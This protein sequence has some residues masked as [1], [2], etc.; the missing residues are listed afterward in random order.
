[1]SKQEISPSVI[2]RL[3]RYHRFLGELAA[4]GTIRISSKELSRQMGLTASQI[5]Q[6]LNCFGGFGQQGYGYNVCA[7]R[8]EIGQILGIHAHRK[9]I[10][11]G[12]GNLGRAIASHVNFSQ[13]GCDLIGLFDSNPFVAGRDIEGMQVHHTDTLSGFC[14]QESPE[15]AILCVPENAAAELANKLVSFGVRA[16]WNF[17][18]SNLHFEDDAV[19]VEN[20][21]LADSLMTL[22]YGLSHDSMDET[23]DSLR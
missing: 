22:T 6:D 1:M 14:R 12:L 15:L 10:L 9:T 20:V 5:R 8:D 4:Q 3:P 13:C 2:R 21:H 19:L 11:I 23:A 17:S 7:L 18:H 16:F